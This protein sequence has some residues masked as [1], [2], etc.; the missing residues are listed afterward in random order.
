MKL[1]GFRKKITTF[2]VCYAF[3]FGVFLFLTGMFWIMDHGNFSKIFYWSILLPALLLIVNNPKSL[4]YVVKSKIGAA[5]ILFATY[6]IITIQWSVSENNWLSLIK[7]PFF[8]FFLFYLVFEL[9]RRRHD[10]LTKSVK[11]TAIAAVLAA[12][13]TLA[14]FY[15]SGNA[16]RLSGYGALSNPLLVSHVFGFFSA[17]WLGSYFAGERNFE[18]KSI[19]SFLICSA[20]LFAT[21]SRTP[22]VALLV[23]IIWLAALSFNKKSIFIVCV[24]I[25]TVCVIFLAFPEAILQRGLSYRTEIWANVLRQIYSQ[26]WFGYGYG[27]SLQIKLAN[28]PYP[29]SDPHNLSL[30]VFFAGGIV[31]IFLWVALYGVALHQSVFLRN[32]KRVLVCSAV[33]VYGLA[34]GMTEGGSFLS[35]PEEHWFLIWIPL[36][37]LAAAT[38]R[39]AI[40]D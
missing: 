30:A 13:V 33:V 20:L 8:V 19:L 25:A 39:E 38:Y 14:Q 9:G 26:I 10:L 36:A 16:G 34:A 3:P 15:V 7:R 37:L 31:G 18:P 1:D 5:F 23:T 2:L 40:N 6:F 28:I 11:Y 27:T 21:G 12:L 29:F 17:I 32:D 4:M 24:L 22:L 35:R